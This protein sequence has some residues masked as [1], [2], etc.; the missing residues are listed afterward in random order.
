MPKRTLGSGFE[1]L[2]D[3]QMM[4]A[5]PV[6]V[7]Y[8]P[9][10][11]GSAEVRSMDWNNVRNASTAAEVHFASTNQTGLQRHYWSDTYYGWEGLAEFAPALPANAIVE[12]AALRLTVTNKI[13]TMNRQPSL[14]VH[15]SVQEAPDAIAT[16]EFSNAV[17]GAIGAVPFA[18]IT[19][20]QELTIP[21]DASLIPTTGNVSLSVRTSDFIAGLEPSSSHN[22]L[23]VFHYSGMR[24]DVRYRVPEGAAA[25]A[26]Q[27]THVK[28]DMPPV[29]VIAEGGSIP[30]LPDLNASVRTAEGRYGMTS[31]GGYLR[32]IGGRY[33][34]YATV[35][36]AYEDDAIT[37]TFDRPITKPTIIRAWSNSSAALGQIY[38]W[39][40]GPAWR[41]DS[42]P[43]GDIAID[44]SP[45]RPIN[46][47]SL[48]SASGRKYGI[49]Y[50]KI[51][52]DPLP[53][54]VENPAPTEGSDGS[55]DMPDEVTDLLTEAVLLS[56]NGPEWRSPEAGEVA[57]E[58]LRKGLHMNM[59][60]VESAAVGLRA[61]ITGGT[62]ITAHI[63]RGSD[64][65]GSVA[66][67]ADGV[68]SYDY[69]EGFSDVLFTT[70]DLATL[71]ASNVSIMTD[72]ML[73]P[74][75][76][77]A[78]SPINSM[79]YALAAAKD[80][81]Q[82]A[83]WSNV[84][85]NFDFNTQ[86]RFLLDRDPTKYTLIRALYSS[87]GGSMFEVKTVRQA[88][89]TD[90]GKPLIE[91]A[92]LQSGYVQ[93]L[94]GNT[95]LIAPGTPQKIYIQMNAQSAQYSFQIQN[96]TSAEGLSP[97]ATMSKHTLD[98][99]L[100]KMN[101]QHQT[102]GVFPALTEVREG[103]SPVF[104]NAGD[105]ANLQ[106][107]VRNDALGGGPVTVDIYVGWHAGEPTRGTLQGT[108]NLSMAGGQTQRISANVSAPGK[109]ADATSDRPI[110]SAVLRLADGTTIENAKLGKEPRSMEKRVYTRNENG[111]TTMRIE[112]EQYTAREQARIH[113]L[114]D[115][116]LNALLSSG[117]SRMTAVR[118][119]LGVD[120]VID[121]IARN[122]AA[123][124]ALA[125]QAE[126]EAAVDAAMATFGEEV[127]E[128]MENLIHD[129]EGIGGS[130]TLSTSAQQLLDRAFQNE[131]PPPEALAAAE[132][133]GD[134]SITPRQLYADAL[135]WTMPTNHPLSSQLGIQQT[136]TGRMLTIGFMDMFA[137]RGN[138]VN[139][140][141]M[142]FKLQLIT[143]IP[144]PRLMLAANTGDAATASSAFKDLLR[145]AQYGS[146]TDSDIETNAP[147]ISM[148][149]PNKTM[150]VTGDTHVRIRFDIAGT[151]VGVRN[152]RV[153][154]GTTLVGISG[155]TGYI[156]VPISNLPV[157]GLMSEAMPE[158]GPSDVATYA[159]RVEV[160][161]S[162]D[163]EI[164][165][166]V[167]PIKMHPNLPI[168]LRSARA[169]QDVVLE[170]SLSTSID[171]ERA[172]FEN[173]V[174]SR[175]A[176]PSD[177]GG[178][179]Y[180]MGSI[181]H[182]G[183][184]LFALDL[185]K[186]SDTGLPMRMP[187]T[188]QIT[189]VNLEAGRIIIKHQT[190]SGEVWYTQYE[191]MTDILEKI[192]GIAYMGKT[193]AAVAEL[194]AEQQAEATTQRALAQATINELIAS[195][196]TVEQGIEFGS[197]G[198]EGAYTTTSHIHQSLY[199]A[200]YQ[201]IDQ[202]KWMEAIQ[203]G[204]TSTADIA[205]RENMKFVWNDNANALVNLPE[206]IVLQRENKINTAG[207]VIDG[208][209]IA[210]AF[211]TGVSAEQRRRVAWDN[212]A[213][214]W[215][216][217]NEGGSYVYSNGKRMKWVFAENIWQ[218]A[219][220]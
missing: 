135:Q 186:P 130:P 61:T 56:H 210:Y 38:A 126:N 28:V 205:G 218:F 102:T 16:G 68:F 128:D 25:P 162:D 171:P 192:T 60:S 129:R 214:G 84:H 155:S 62:A 112:S 190:S 17:G 19:P 22:S 12:S 43:V 213:L 100:L 26:P 110:I 176:F 184:N 217:V 94:D 177:I 220:E 78:I 141:A 45:E 65:L 11:H 105:I 36:N 206:G 66:V 168:D 31:T 44:A 198:N 47:V 150:Y 8:A 173:E 212:D 2:E 191:H 15:L 109:P 103:S 58:S 137:Q 152:V 111:T 90:N 136:V 91:W 121:L 165:R 59:R 127:A 106:Y 3:R 81:Q 14:V 23:S 53:I 169:A 146:I 71:T 157:Q 211:E 138:A 172:R 27:P 24:L 115:R 195:T 49:D 101:D 97:P 82:P 104:A 188:G 118:D 113:E 154:D 167:E 215:F 73:E 193:E 166:L 151:N 37:L 76:G 153:Y 208:I 96:A 125:D 9:T 204:F 216:E 122:T 87:G 189:H 72:E 20:G 145:E 80:L 160:R 134:G 70:P 4:D 120:H 196:L 199:D 142:A 7:E 182:N 69:N 10:A 1:K 46:T 39:V 174:L 18:D 79:S 131:N 133:V 88:G 201:P 63:Y 124:L 74:I 54:P 183:R 219:Q 114:T 89:Y 52:A 164:T 42:T 149:E 170:G 33:G 180:L 51:E 117:D 21:L 41:V 147:R 140:W 99:S 181:H 187:A 202:F 178:W 75:T 185:G 161:L 13:D 6:S 207:E 98:V 209:N 55:F 159:L 119:T 50:L 30:L 93:I 175:M 86:G 156:N 108:F 29:A 67:P 34:E 95:V 123:A 64:L 32:S 83:S 179:S 139:Q 132:I 194:T 148:A 158:T 77:D 40:N 35:D 116:A 5:D 197:V 85:Y 200:N 203:P 107:H 143:D 57:A 144:A 163:T 48:L 92:G